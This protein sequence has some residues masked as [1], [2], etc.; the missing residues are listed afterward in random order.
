[1]K[2]V[3]LLMGYNFKDGD[4]VVAA[5]D[6]REKANRAMFMYSEEEYDDMYVKEMEVQ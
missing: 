2:K 3:Y 6:S 1:M 5:F 4:Y